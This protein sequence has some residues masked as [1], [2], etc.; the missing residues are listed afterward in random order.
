MPLFLHGCA[1]VKQWFTDC[2]IH[3]IIIQTDCVRKGS[4]AVYV[5]QPDI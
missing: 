5:Q 3:A 1:I 2:Q 4:V